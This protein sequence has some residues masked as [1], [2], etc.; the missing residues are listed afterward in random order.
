M[1]IVSARIYRRHIFCFYL[2]TTFDKHRFNPYDPK[3]QRRFKAV[4]MQIPA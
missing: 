1:L 2:T 3:T 4:V